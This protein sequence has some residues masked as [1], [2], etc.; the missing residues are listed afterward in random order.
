MSIRI[1]EHLRQRFDLIETCPIVRGPSEPWRGKADLPLGGLWDVGFAIDQDLLLIVSATG[2][3]VIDCASGTCVARDDDP[4]FDVD[5]G[6]ML[7][8]GIGPIAGEPVRVGGLHGGGLP[9]QTD[10]GWQVERYPLAWPDEELIFSP[11]G[12]SMLWTPV[13]VPYGLARLG[14]FESE[15]RDFGFS[16]SGKVFVV[17]TASDV[18]IHH[19]RRDTTPS[20]RFQSS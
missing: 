2:R 3:G 10:D 9:K 13:G 15:V 20:T 12:Q 11:P 5:Y 4:D 8:P 17:A 14:G 1:P 6:N 19:R 16:P 7:V 18:A